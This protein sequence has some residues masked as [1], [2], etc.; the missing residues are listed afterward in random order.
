MASSR[1]SDRKILVVEDEYFLA[2]DIC[3]TL[4]AQGAVIVGPVPSVTKA[5]DLIATANQIDGSVLDVN[6]GGD[7]VFPVVDAL[8]EREVPVLMITGYSEA[9]IPERYA[10]LPRRQKP[11]T[12]EDI[13]RAVEQ[14]IA[15]SRS[16]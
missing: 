5:L 10:T 11:I 2:D 8:L 6:L 3:Q 9:D 1:L 14:S 12:P 13:A 7:L 4:E 16:S 15:V